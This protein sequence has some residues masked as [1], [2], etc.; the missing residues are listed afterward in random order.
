MIM[1]L[2]QPEAD[3]EYLDTNDLAKL[4]KQKAQTWRKRRWRG[5]SPPFVKLGNR[6]LYRR[7]DVERYLAERTFRNTSEATARTVGPGGAA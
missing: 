7:S 2:H 4:T 3:N 6:V 5:D 1:S